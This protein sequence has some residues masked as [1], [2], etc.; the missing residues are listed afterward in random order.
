MR[1]LTQKLVLSVVTMALVVVAL[2]TSTFA[3][4]T[5]TN[6]ASVSSFNAQVTSGEGIEISLGTWTGG[7][8]TAGGSATITSTSVWYTVLPN[9]AIIARLVE[10]YG[11]S[12]TSE[13]PVP[14]FRFTDL[15][16]VNGADIRTKA[17]VA[18]VNGSGFIPLD[19]F[20]RSAVAQDIRV[21]N[22]KLT[23]TSKSWVADVRSFTA[24]NGKVY[25]TDASNFPSMTVAAWTSAR[26]SIVG[27]NGFGISGT[28]TVFE[29]AENLIVTPGEELTTI[30][31]SNAVPAYVSSDPAYGGASYNYAK[32]NA[33]DIALLGAMPSTLKVAEGGTFDADSGTVGDQSYANVVRTSSATISG[34]TQPY[35]YAGIKVRIWIEGFDADSFDAIFSTVLSVQLAFDAIPV[36]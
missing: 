25:G 32:G 26:L 35:T 9:S 36:K 7:L 1:K 23:G 13:N 20:F 22:V 31:N 33:S 11:N 10:M 6:S 15:T 27:V 19:V 24:S 14:N 30:Y 17:N 12:G 3:W 21:T 34:I 5:L 2:G 8:A 18:A 16:S 28:T 29:R 4:F